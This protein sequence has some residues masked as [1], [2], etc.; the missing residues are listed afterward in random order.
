MSTNKKDYY[1][2]LEV[3]RTASTE[4]IKKAYKKMALKW[5]PDRN[6]NNR[7]E[8]EK[9]F[10][11]IN[12]AYNVLVNERKREQY[13]RHGEMDDGD[14]ASGMGG[15][16]MPPDFFSMFNAFGGGGMQSQDHNAIRIGAA[17]VKEI[18]LKMALEELYVG[19]TVHYPITQII[20]CEICNGKGAVNPDDIL[21][22]DLCDG[23]G[24]IMKMMRMGPMIQQRVEQC[25]KCHGAGKSIKEGC[26]C[27]TCAGRKSVERRKNVDFYLKP[28]S[29]QGDKYILKNDG[30]WNP[31]FSEIGALVFVILES[32][33]PHSF[34]REG[35]NL[36]LNKSLSLA[37]ALCG[38]VFLVK[39]LDGRMLKVD[40][41]GMIIRSDDI[42]KMVGEGMPLKNDQYKKGDLIIRFNI[43]FPEKL[44]D[45]RKIYLRKILPKLTPQI[46]DLNPNDYKDAEEKTLEKVTNYNQSQSQQQQMD[47]IDDINGGM[48]DFMQ[49]AQNVQCAQQ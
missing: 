41:N 11:S 29:Q 30:D 43:E 19:K 25:Y 24:Q 31:G 23:R 45:E 28:G 39:Q 44:T 49:Q 32:Q 42:M 9:Q 14:L 33:T 37:D 34:K 17:P 1:E 35:A 3:A 36:V 12:K 38:S 47:D 5:H 22:C 18:H 48:S 13:D 2:L 6:I 21:K 26:A 10:T 27:G 15:V 16:G 7:E 8:S 46:W 20:K 4:E 40:T